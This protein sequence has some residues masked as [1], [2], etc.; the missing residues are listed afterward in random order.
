MKQNYIGLVLSTLAVAG[1]T[2][3]LLSCGR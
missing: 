1:V 3:S 2:L